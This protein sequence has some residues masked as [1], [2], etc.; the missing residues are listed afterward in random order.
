[1]DVKNIK[2][3]IGGIL[4][5]LPQIV[6][7]LSDALPQKYASMLSAIGFLYMGYNAKDK[8]VTGGTKPQ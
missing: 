8:E 2:T 5:A 1:M 4:A 7:A 3:T 6:S